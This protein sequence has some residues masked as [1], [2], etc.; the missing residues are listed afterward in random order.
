MLYFAISP[1]AINP[2]CCSPEAPTSPA[3]F[4]QVGIQLG[5]GAISFS[6]TACPPQSFVKKKKK[7]SQ[8]R[9]IGENSRLLGNVYKKTKK[10]REETE[11]VATWPQRRGW[12]GISRSAIGGDPSVACDGWHYWA[13]Y[14]LETKALSP[15]CAFSMN[16]TSPPPTPS[17]LIKWLQLHLAIRG[18]PLQRLDKGL[19]SVAC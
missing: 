15:S 16:Y 14:V 4:P 11:M 12:G 8:R 1:S 19:L 3:R 13:K 6:A 10:E 2:H 17:F 5:A 9:P 18:S 7:K